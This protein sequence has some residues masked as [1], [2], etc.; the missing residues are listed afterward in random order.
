ML[1]TQHS[2]NLCRIKFSE[3]V[4]YKDGKEKPKIEVFFTQHQIVQE[5]KERKYN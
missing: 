1:D 3:L 4:K 5:K 2:I